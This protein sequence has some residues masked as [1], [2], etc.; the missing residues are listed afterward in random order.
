M[1]GVNKDLCP[2][3]A[4]PVLSK[5]AEEF[6][7]KGYVRPAVL[8]KIGDNHFGSIPGSSTTHASVERQTTWFE[9]V[10]RFDLNWHVFKIS[11]NSSTTLISQAVEENKRC[12]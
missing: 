11:R 1:K 6:V 7:V 3:S 5:I 9:H 12:N 4:N 10:Q 8:K 2:T